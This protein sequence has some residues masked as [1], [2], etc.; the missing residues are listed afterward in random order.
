MLTEVEVRNIPKEFASFKIYAS[1]LR[2]SQPDM[3]F[4]DLL[5]MPPQSFQNFLSLIKIMMTVSMSTAVVE[6]GF[7]HY[8]MNIVKSSTHTV[9]GNDTMYNLLEIKLNRPSIKDFDAEPA[10]YPLAGQ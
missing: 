9:L 8:H 5:L 6:Q 4:R 10:N 1:K 3:V 7:S 2:T